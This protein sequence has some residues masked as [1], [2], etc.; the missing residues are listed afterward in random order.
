MAELI[1]AILEEEEIQALEPDF[2]LLTIIP[3]ELAQ[4][5]QVIIFG[6]EKKKELKLLTTNNH[7]EEVKKILYQIEQKGYLYKIFYTT[8]EGFEI[9]LQRYTLLEELENKKAEQLK[10][11]AKAE[12]KSAVALIKEQF[13]QRESQDPAQFINTIIRLGFQAGASDLHFQPEENGI[14]LRL[15]IDGVLN[16]IVQFSHQEF[17]KY[18]QKIKFMSGVKMNIDYL[19][20]DWRFSFE[21]VDRNWNQKKIDAR[22]SFMPWI[23]TESIVIRFLDAT[24]SIDDFKDIG[25]EEHH[26]HTLKS[27]LKKTNG[28][29]IMTGPTWS[30]KTTTLYAILKKLNDGTKKIITL[31]DPIEYKIAGLQQS[32]INYDKHYDYETWLKAILRQD[33]DII[34]VGE[35]RTKETAQIA[36]NASLTG[37]LVFTTLHTNSALDS[38]SR[39]MNMGIEPYLLTPALQLIIG[40]R[41]VRKICPH[42]GAWEDANPEEDTEIRKNLTEIQRINPELGKQYQGKIFKGKGCEYCNHSGYQGRIAMIEILEINDTLREKLMKGNQWENL[43]PLAQALGFIP[44]QADGILKVIEGI[45][46]LTEVHRVLY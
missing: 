46:D 27:Y 43:L 37:H 22:I 12:W 32:Q 15:R 6:K 38:L 9:A 21:A 41:L 42:C 3:K 19:P 31:E 39:L 13:E 14:V 2:S 18:M 35:T 16:Q 36:I 7:P 44:M 11:E 23:S 5:A 20:Q 29:I 25:F 10:Q 45:T 24:E 17:W 26:L 4:K 34:L 1:K 28:I 33:P 30:G 8:N 40:Q